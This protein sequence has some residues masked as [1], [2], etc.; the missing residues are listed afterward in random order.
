MTVTLS[1]GKIDFIGR[2][3]KITDAGNIGVFS[4]VFDIFSSSKNELK[5]QVDLEGFKLQRRAKL[6]DTS[7]NFAIANGQFREADGELVIE[8][9]INVLSNYLLFFYGVLI[10]F[11][12]IIIVIL[13][14]SDNKSSVIAIPFI[15]LHGAIMF[16]VRYFIMRRSVKS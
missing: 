15:I 14:F 4:S 7:M 16:A 12:F 13:L 5:G 6:F 11:Y 2:L 1:I 3:Y 8:T 9:E 10:I